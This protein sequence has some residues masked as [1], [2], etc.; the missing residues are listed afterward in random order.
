MQLCVCRA[1]AEWLSIVLEGYEFEGK[2]E[3]RVQ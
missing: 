2:K 3:K 1:S